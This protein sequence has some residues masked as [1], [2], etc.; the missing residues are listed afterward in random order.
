M[1]SIVLSKSDAYINIG[2]ARAWRE[3]MLQHTFSAWIKTACQSPACL[4]SLGNDER[5]VFAVDIN[6]SGHPPRDATAIA[7]KYAGA[8]SSRF[9]NSPGS[10]LQRAPVAKT[11][12]PMKT[13]GV[14]G[15]LLGDVAG[16]LRVSLE[17]D[18]G[19][20]LI[21]ETPLPILADNSWHLIQVSVESGTSIQVHVDGN[22][23]SV[24]YVSRQNLS[25]LDPNRVGERVVYPSHD[26][27]CARYSKSDGLRD[28]FCGMLADVSVEI[29]RPGGH[30]LHWWVTEAGRGTIVWDHG[31][32][33]RQHPQGLHLNLC[34][35]GWDTEDFPATSLLLNGYEGRRAE[36]AEL[37]ETKLEVL[38]KPLEQHVGAEGS[39]SAATSPQ[40]AAT[41]SGG[42]TDD[43]ARGTSS[44]ISNPLTPN[45]F[46]KSPMSGDGSGG[47]PAPLTFS[48][49][50]GDDAQQAPV[51]QTM[52][53]E[54]FE[55]VAR[56]EGRMPMS[57]SVWI[58]TRDTDPAIVLTAPFKNPV[59][60]ILNLDC[61]PSVSL[62]NGLDA[63]VSQCNVTD[64]K[65]HHVRWV[66][67]PKTGASLFL[68]GVLSAWQYVALRV[69]E[70]AGGLKSVA[71][72][73]NLRS[74]KSLS[75]LKSRNKSSASFAP[76]DEAERTPES[77][78]TN[79]ATNGEFQEALRRRSLVTS[80]LQMHAADRD[81][82]VSDAPQGAERRRS[83]AARQS[84]TFLQTATVATV[85]Q[86]V[87]NDDAAFSAAMSASTRGDALQSTASFAVDE[88]ELFGDLLE[89]LE[90]AGGDML[91][92]AN[93][94][95]SPSKL[96]EAVIAFSE[97]SPTKPSLSQGFKP[98][99]ARG[100]PQ[101]PPVAQTLG[102]Q[103][104]LISIKKRR[105]II[106]VLTVMMQRAMECSKRIGVSPGVSHA[107]V[108]L[109][110]L[111]QG[112]SLTTC[113]T[114]GSHF[115]GELREAV[116]KIGL[117]TFTWRFDK[118]TGREVP[119][120]VKFV[121]PFGEFAGASFTDDSLLFTPKEE[122]AQSALEMQAGFT[123]F[124]H[125]AT[126]PSYQDNVKHKSRLAALSEIRAV[127]ALT[128]LTAIYP[129]TVLPFSC[130][131]LDDTATL[132][133]GGVRIPLD[134]SS[135][136][137]DTDLFVRLRKSGAH[138]GHVL[139]IESVVIVEIQKQRL[140]ITVP[141]WMDEDLREQT[142]AT[143]PNVDTKY[144]A[145]GNL[146]LVACSSDTNIFEDERWHH[147]RVVIPTLDSHRGIRVLVDEIPLELSTLVVMEQFPGLGSL[148]RRSTFAR[149]GTVL[150]RQSASMTADAI[151]DSYLAVDTPRSARS[152]VAFWNLPSPEVDAR[153]VNLD[154]GFKKNVLL[155]KLDSAVLPSAAQAAHDVQ[156]A[157][158]F[159]GGCGFFG[160]VL[161]VNIICNGQE[162]QWPLRDSCRQKLSRFPPLVEDRF[163]AHGK[164]KP[165][166]P[167]I[168][169]SPSLLMCDGDSNVHT[170]WAP[171]SLP[172][173]ALHFDGHASFVSAVNL[174]S[175]FHMSNL[176]KFAVSVWLKSGSPSDPT[177]GLTSGCIMT[178]HDL[179][180]PVTEA[181]CGI[182]THTRVDNRSS[183]LKRVFSPFLTSFLL[184]DSC[185]R[186]L[187]LE[188]DFDIYDGL[189]HKIQWVVYDASNN[190]SHIFVD[191]SS[192]PCRM[193]CSDMPREFSCRNPVL[194]LGARNEGDNDINTFFVGE[195]RNF[196]FSR[197][198]NDDIL[199]WP[200]TEGE[201]Y[202]L[203]DELQ[204][205][206]GCSWAPEWIYTPF[207]PMTPVLSD[208]S[209]IEFSPVNDMEQVANEQPIWI[210]FSIKSNSTSI[211]LVWSIVSADRCSLASFTA[212]EGGDHERRTNDP[213]THILRLQRVVRKAIR[214]CPSS[215]GAAVG[216][217]LL[218]PH[219][220]S[221]DLG[222]S[223]NF[224]GLGGV[225]S[226][227]ALDRSDR[228][229]AAP[230]DD[231]I[232]TSS[233]TVTPRH[234]TM[235]ATTPKYRKKIARRA[236]LMDILKEQR[237]Q[238]RTHEVTFCA[239]DGNHEDETP[240]AVEAAA[241]KRARTPVRP[242]TRTRYAMV[243]EERAYQLHFKDLCD[244]KWHSVTLRIPAATNM[245]EAP[246]VFIDELDTNARHLW[247]ANI[248]ELPDDIFQQ[249][250]AL[251]PTN[252]SRVQDRSHM[253]VLR[254]ELS[255][256]SMVLGKAAVTS[257]PSLCCC[258]R[259]FGVLIHSKREE[260][261]FAPFAST[262][263]KTSTTPRDVAA[264]GVCWE[265]SV[266]P[267][268]CIALG[269]ERYILIPPLRRLTLG[270]FEVSFMLRT[271][272]QA[273]SCVLEFGS[274]TNGYFCV[275]LNQDAFG[276]DAPNSLRLCLC[277][278]D[279]RE[280]HASCF[281]TTDDAEDPQTSRKL[282]D[283]DA[284]HSVAVRVFDAAAN[285]IEF[286][287]DGF[288]PQV[289][290]ANCG[291]PS[292]FLELT[293]G[294]TVGA[295][296][297]VLDPTY[298]LFGSVKQLMFSIFSTDFEAS[299][300]SNS[301]MQ[302]R[303]RMHAAAGTPRQSRQNEN[304]VLIAHYE[305][306]SGF[307]TILTDR[308]GFRNHA[309]AVKPVWRSDLQRTWPTFTIP[310]KADDVFS[311][312]NLCVS[313][314]SNNPSDKIEKNPSTREIVMDEFPEDGWVSGAR[315]P[316]WIS[317]DLGSCHTVFCIEIDMFRGMT[318]KHE[319]YV[320][321]SNLS[322][323]ATFSGL[324][325]VG[326]ERVPQATLLETICMK[327]ASPR[328]MR[329]HLQQPLWGLRWIRV[330]ATESLAPVA[331]ANIRVI[332]VRGE[333]S[334]SRKYSVSEV[335]GRTPSSAA[336]VRDVGPMLSMFPDS[337]APAITSN[338]LTSGAGKKRSKKNL[339]KEVV[340]WGGEES[341]DDSGSFSIGRKGKDSS[342]VKDDSSP[343]HT[344]KAAA[345]LQSQE[346]SAW[347]EEQR[348]ANQLREDTLQLLR[349]SAAQREREMK[350]VFYT[351]DVERTG[352]I[353]LADFLKIFRQTDVT[354][355]ISDEQVLSFLRDV[356]VTDSQVNFEQ[357]MKVFARREA[358]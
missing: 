42:T 288:F 38:A 128:G 63:F 151:A 260:L 79:I 57:F 317:I 150:H 56:E 60:M 22:I 129:K 326:T 345:P 282:L 186:A 24:H 111:K 241:T 328:T 116:V 277:D 198:I 65:W 87:Q 245:L 225:L 50:E 144:L 148:Q 81:S 102:Q 36:V 290:F 199:H 228:K 90:D 73:G 95:D 110:S 357:F 354:G 265:L 190:E 9:W 353:S 174:R 47:T 168:P 67:D 171:T 85:A 306:T 17:D 311:S 41:G 303:L 217:P 18:E 237:H 134:K 314:W 34:S 96:V 179:K 249:I 231:L 11:L 61:K 218:S 323:S 181:S 143:V 279:G 59:H 118:G 109:P 108:P 44:T 158:T 280:L 183:P 15:A 31:S 185:A 319:I 113:L 156:L 3:Y 339:R 247:T 125:I 104:L 106:R 259:N 58:N 263:D 246:Q 154:V 302:S 131:L 66:I 72:V 32:G 338:V 310:S 26:L 163:A 242:G 262:M 250:A 348:I 215:D 2:C 331:Y 264:T 8:A 91:L 333:W 121:N 296:L 257:S 341:D 43:T 347:S 54:Y 99:S 261:L 19:N 203:N 83:R 253:E 182:F 53:R 289:R 184:I 211:G 39:L 92:K 321:N 213:G 88:G 97:S 68:N 309:M 161:Q 160:S 278:A 344:N 70:D 229:A 98:T 318:S 315:G 224:G 235:S 135:T 276:E 243:Q 300:M 126:T 222:D 273:P 233:L 29:G 48:A 16:G 308:S 335:L 192:V 301:I 80:L 25:P 274:V 202:L 13:S 307:A 77:D 10:R 173:K 78:I 152:S 294:G 299:L 5:E 350:I 141:A 105:E 40:H 132:Q 115:V 210:T 20:K 175:N 214:V 123:S 343:S 139:T 223:I 188:I 281:L 305:L 330:V 327:P 358:W 268:S 337:F 14:H 167:T 207:P 145:N 180:R 266:P 221:N 329:V 256:A 346:S 142:K 153:T 191:D 177:V 295:L 272:T 238:E 286:E 206:S 62:V 1:S 147:L 176:K 334:A 55:R 172:S 100:S 267:K 320:S 178:V 28:Y 324:Q 12:R 252:A 287:V 46:V 292:R 340:A 216:T 119:P 169:Q 107:D 234:S 291:S 122:H 239:P 194:N 352:V 89:E 349:K 209:I 52:N 117:H 271:T 130:A 313:R 45:A 205:V 316:Q 124:S 138:Y 82:A 33:A 284:W 187:C 200:M 94:H 120:Q 127:M 7:H 71:S 208:D 30:K 64:G 255:W 164:M 159:C 298:S 195:M 166:H 21:A 285:H 232:S 136:G 196:R 269:A 236:E 112:S 37:D 35:C 230:L 27:L 49:A 137:L 155:R 189:W 244:G 304:K 325:N 336:L 165:P 356:G 193:V 86:Q 4:V 258:V 220:S 76:V 114:F 248:R 342:W 322:K 204:R 197:D 240:A 275:M 162:Y 75:S 219:L 74:S 149:R 6:V 297:D 51:S 226:P 101:Q 157:D 312:A 103:F 140:I 293:E 212:N 332:A 251:P 283:D 69:D 146:R 201:G 170:H 254:D 355:L 133:L 93:S 23:L 270:A 84:I 351:Q 227:K